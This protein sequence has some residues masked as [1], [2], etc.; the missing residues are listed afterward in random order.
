MMRICTFLA[1]AGLLAAPAALAGDG[2]QSS[3]EDARAAIAA[4]DFGRAEAIYTRLAEAEPDNLDH[5]TAVARVKGWRGDWAG[6]RAGYDEVLR[7]NPRHYDALVGKA[8][9]ALFQRRLDEA[10]ELLQRAEEIAGP[11]VELH[12]AWARVHRAYGKSR[13]ERFEARALQSLELQPDNAE[14]KTLLDQAR[15][16]R[17]IGPLE[18]RVSYG[19]DQLSQAPVGHVQAVSFGWR[20]EVNSVHGVYERWRRFGE[21]GNRAGLAYSVQ[22][23]GNWRLRGINLL[24]ESKGG[25]IPTH[26]HTVG[27]FRPLHSRFAGGV[28]FRYLGFPDVNVRVL[29]PTGEFYFNP[30]TS[31]EGTVFLSQVRHRLAVDRSLSKV[32]ALGLLRVQV[33]RGLQVAGGYSRGSQGYFAYTSDRLLSFHTNTFIGRTEFRLRPTVTAGVSFAW[34]QRSNNTSQ[35]GFGVHVTFR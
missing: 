29:A 21:P 17:G 30:R 31:L 16:M 22:F 15:D 14:A 13:R 4:R 32:T 18:V 24:G 25:V 19:R 2:N 3:E 27:I 5:A 9:I 35:Q 11:N 28:D 7:R 6:A 20:G 34:E 8:Q 1:S 23:V 26:D 12:L 10:E 33:R